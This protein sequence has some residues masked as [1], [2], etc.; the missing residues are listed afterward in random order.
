MKFSKILLIVSLFSS[1]SSAGNVNKINNFNSFLNQLK[2]IKLATKTV[3]KANINNQVMNIQA[4]RNLALGEANLNNNVVIKIKLEKSLYYLNNY[5]SLLS[6][7][8]NS[9]SIMY[10]KSSFQIHN[11][12]FYLVSKNKIDQ[13]VQKLLSEKKKILKLKNMYFELYKIKLKPIIYLNN[14]VSMILGNATQINRMNPI[15]SYGQNINT[16]NINGHAIT[17]FCTENKNCFGYKIKS[18]NQTSF[19]IKL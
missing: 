11:K 13:K 5:L 8:F 10:A 17:N 15:A 2:E 3:K 6:K 12:Y 16:G 7:Q 19:K 18:I 1:L 4:Q 9:N 14:Q